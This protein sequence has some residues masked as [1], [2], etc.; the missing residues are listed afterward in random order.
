MNIQEKGL[1]FDRWSFDVLKKDHVQKSKKLRRA[2]EK[3]KRKAANSIS[4]E[5]LEKELDRLTTHRAALLKETRYM[6][7]ED[8]DR[9]FTVMEAEI[10][11]LKRLLGKK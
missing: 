9:D 7:S 10:E 1:A 5:R 4:R 3:L 2:K 6:N 8:I 11:L